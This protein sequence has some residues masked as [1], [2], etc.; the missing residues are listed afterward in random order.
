MKKCS[1]LVILLFSMMIISCGPGKSVTPVDLYVGSWNMLVEDTPQGDVSAI[2]KIMKSAEGT[3]SG[4][5]SS[6]L[7][8]FDLYDFKLV[9]DTLSAGFTIQDAEFNLSGT[10][11]SLLFKGY[12]SGMGEDFKTSGKKIID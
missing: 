5:L 1:L 11:D 6:D 8:D 3:Y 4:N 7:G 2:I 10:F 12:V 9:D